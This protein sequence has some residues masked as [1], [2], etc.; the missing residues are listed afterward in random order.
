MLYALLVL[1]IL[2][3]TAKVLSLRRAADELR[4]QITARLTQDTNVG[5]DVSTRDRSMRALTRVLDEAV[6]AL[7]ERELRYRQGGRELDEAV[8][9]ISHDLRTP[10]TAIRGYMELLRA[11]ALPEQAATYLK[12]IGGRLD[13]LTRLAEE[14]F[15]YSVVLASNQ[16][17]QRESLDLR[18]AVEEALAAH[19]TLLAQRGIQPKIT[20]PESPV[21]RS[22]NPTA[23]SRI[24]SNL[25]SNAARYSDGDLT[26]AL[27]P[28]G[29]LTIS[30]HASSLDEVTVARLFERY[31]T[32]ENGR[33]GT[34]LGLSIARNLTDAMDGC[35]TAALSEGI[36]TITLVFPE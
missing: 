18:P 16:Y 11:M 4:A 5:I 15:Q 31:Y 30:N 13:T 7:R 34:G 33:S 8:S 22:L 24:L 12:V 20:M 1:L 3:L 26:V 36:L 35:V 23:V 10:L 19:Y 9:N 25:M 17:A 27:S 29:A 6:R 32:V 21:F 28:D 2:L 14:L